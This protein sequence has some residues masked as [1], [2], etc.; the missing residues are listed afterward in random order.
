[1]KYRT[2]VD[3]HTGDVGVLDENGHLVAEF[4]S[5]VTRHDERATAAAMH[6][7]EHFCAVMNA[8]PTEAVDVWAE[9]PEYPSENW[10]YEADNGDTRLGYWDWVEA[11][12]DA[13]S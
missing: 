1:M 3:P 7:A 6:L 11:Q 13:N 2:K 10:R 4:Y 12:R 5:A 8:R 9:D